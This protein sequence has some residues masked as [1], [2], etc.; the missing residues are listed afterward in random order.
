MMKEEEIEIFHL[1]LCIVTQRLYMMT[2]TPEKGD[3]PCLPHGLCMA[4]TYT[5]LTTG[6]KHIAIVIKNKMAALITI[7]KSVK[8]T[9]VVAVNRV[10][11]VEVMPGTLEKLDKIQEI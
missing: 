9:W 2:Q 4:N 3:E 6:S 7:G 10:P 5:K 8:I 11:S 1:K